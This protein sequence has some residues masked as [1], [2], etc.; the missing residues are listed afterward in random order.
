MSPLT[1]RL[2]EDDF[3]DA[4]KLA[5]RAQLMSPRGLF[6]TLISPALP[7]IVIYT[8]GIGGES[9]WFVAA[10]VFLIAF[11]ALPLGVFWSF[12]RA[13]RTE[14]QAAHNQVDNTFDWTS[15]GLAIRSEKASNRPRWEDLH[16]YASNRNVLIMFVSRRLILTVP[17][18]VLTDGQFRQLTTTM[19]AAGVPDWLRWHWNESSLREAKGVQR[20]TAPPG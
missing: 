11:I 3:Y 13:A 18:R 19:V 1:Y 7:V 10:A 17:R 12:R 2:S 6:L 15:D 9:S 8:L 20:P 16:G 4:M 5:W 14:S